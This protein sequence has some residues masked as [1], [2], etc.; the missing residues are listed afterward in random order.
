MRLLVGWSAFAVLLFQTLVIGGTTDVAV[1]ER[2]PWHHAHHTERSRNL[3]VRQYTNTSVPLYSDPAV[4]PQLHE[5]YRCTDTGSIEAPT[6]AWRLTYED[7]K[8]KLKSIQTQNDSGTV[9]TYLYDFYG[10]R[11]TF[12]FNPVAGSYESAWFPAL[13]DAFQQ[14]NS[15]FPPTEPGPALG[16]QGARNM[17]ALVGKPGYAQVIQRGWW[18]SDLHTNY[19]NQAAEQNLSLV[20]YLDNNQMV[21]VAPWSRP[22]RAPLSALVDPSSTSSQLNYSMVNFEGVPW[23]EVLYATSFLSE[24]EVQMNYT[25]ASIFTDSCLQLMISS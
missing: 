15:T 3:A 14:L 22:A 21:G 5:I 7:D 9:F 13:V 2:S 18:S 19:Y 11:Q 24:T 20:A 1:S 23:L 6:S 17:N 10:N 16:S 12:V 8:D 25:D 4:G